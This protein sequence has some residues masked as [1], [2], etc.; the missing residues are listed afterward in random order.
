MAQGVI[1]K[2]HIA[3][4]RSIVNETIEVSNFNIFVGKND[5]GKSNVLKALDMFFNYSPE[6]YKFNENFSLIY[7]VPKNKAKEIIIELTIEIPN[8]FVDAGEVVW[9]KVW[10]QDGLHEDSFNREFKLYSRS[11]VFLKRIHYE[12][13][14]AVKSGEYFKDLLAKLYMAMLNIS[15][16]RLINANSNYTDVLKLMTEELTRIIE[17]NLHIHSHLQ[18]PYDMQI[19][20]RD[21]FIQTK[22]G[23]NDIPLNFRGD[24]V[25]ARHIPSI[26]KF[27]YNR[28]INDVPKNTVRGVTIWGYEE[29]ENGVELNA[30]YELAQ[31]FLGYSSELQLFVTTHSPA[32]YGLKNENSVLLYHTKKENGATKYLNS[33]KI[34]A[35]DEE[36]G[37]LPLIEPYMNNIKK[38]VARLNCEN[39]IIKSQVQF[40]ESKV[41]NIIIFTEGKTDEI[42]IS[43]ALKNSEFYD[44]VVFNPNVTKFGESE[45][46]KLYSELSKS[47]DENIKICI[48]DRDVTIIKQHFDKSTNK[49]YKFSIPAPPHRTETEKISIEHYFT[50]EQIKT[51][52]ENGHRLFMAKEF[53][54]EGRIIDG[55]N[56]FTPYTILKQKDYYPLK[57]LDGNEPKVEVRKCN[58]KQN[59]ALSKMKFAKYVI[60]SHTGFEFDLSVFNP[61]VEVIKEII[62]DA[63]RD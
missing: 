48:F 15:N 23:Q 30:C 36:L 3:H 57:I 45:L 11:L 26:L 28:T 58:S 22:D 14:P 56:Y 46:S 6:K 41:G 54:D 55:D 17:A 38:E 24:G 34:R 59:I 62:T 8:N 35:L 27:I 18:M 31:E 25:Q 10:R 43:E 5:V 40:L 33:V 7:N 4:F 32:F 63:S 44:K 37:I 13:V 49:V 16:S 19:L 20:F 53:N 2:I 21:L 52:D 39:A 51:F 12:Y 60:D 61:I 47:K 29:P 1:K 50:D 9:R 42:F